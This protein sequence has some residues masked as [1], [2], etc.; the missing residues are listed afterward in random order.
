LPPSTTEPVTTTTTTEAVTTTLPPPTEAVFEAGEASNTLEIHTGGDVDHELV[1]VDDRMAVRS[2]NGSPLAAGD[3]NDV[4]DYYLQFN[5]PDSVIFES[6]PSAKVQIEVEFLDDGTDTFSI[7]YDA[8]SSSA[9]DPRFKDTGQ[10]VK[11]GTG[12]FQTAVFPLCDAFFT[13]RTNGGDFRIADSADGAETIS[14]IR[15]TVAADDARE[16]HVDSCGAS[17]LDDIADSAAI[18]ACVDQACPGDTVLFTSGGGDSNYRGYLV[19]QTVFLLR[20]AARSDISFS[21]TDQSDHALLTATADLLGPVVRLYARS[22]VPDPGNID[23]ITISSIDVDGNRDERLC[24]GPDGVGNGDGDNWGS[25]LPECEVF[26]DPWC[27]PTSLAMDGAVSGP[28]DDYQ[29]E[30]ELWSTGLVVSDMT[31]SNTECGTALAFWGAAGTIESVTIDTAGD[32]VHGAGCSQTDPDEAIGGWSDGITFV[33]PDNTIVG[34]HILDASDIGIVTFGGS[35]IVITGNTVEAT[36]GNHGMFAGIAVHPFQRGVMAG[37]EVSSNEIINVADDVCGGIHTGIDIGAHMWAAGCSSNPWPGSLGLPGACTSL[38][39]PPGETYCVPG[40]T[41]RT[42][43]YVP[44]G[45]T[46]TLADNMVTGA[47]VNYLVE[48]V[49][50]AGELVVSGNNSLT[51]RWTDWEGDVACVWDGITDS[52]GPLDFVAHDPA[53]D[54]WIDQRIYCER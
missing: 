17:P 41:C 34:N 4:A 32:H 36:P 45:T 12:T 20:T 43:G 39:A 30:P 48:G 28:G 7:Q 13:N 37:M 23:D 16:I 5:V 11:T 2:G 18:Q 31:I 14:K 22:S 27:S 3:G 9:G 26:D 24:I 21:S 40:Q 6:Q 47:Q 10:V 15:V 33:G 35:G 49:D 54:G 8:A 52:W 25:W 50:V 29:S 42:W 44:A 1:T 46:F 19:E 38:S 51:S 53:L